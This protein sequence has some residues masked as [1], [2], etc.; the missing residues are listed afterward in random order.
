M[1]QL[2]GGDDKLVTEQSQLSDARVSGAS[3]FSSISQE[4]SIWTGKIFQ[5]VLIF[6]WKFYG[7]IYVEYDF[8]LRNKLNLS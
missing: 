1:L 4:T 5:K 7:E 2:I 6:S 8:L 3:E